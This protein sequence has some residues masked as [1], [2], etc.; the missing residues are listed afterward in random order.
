M[1]VPGSLAMTLYVFAQI[2]LWLGAE[3]REARARLPGG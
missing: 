3:E 2:Y 1:L